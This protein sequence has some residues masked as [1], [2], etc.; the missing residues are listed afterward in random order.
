MHRDPQKFFFS[1][2]KQ[3]SGRNDDHEWLRMSNAFIL[4][5]LLWKV[6]KNHAGTEKEDLNQW[7]YF[8][9]CV[10]ILISLLCCI[11]EFPM[12]E[13]C[14]T[15]RWQY[16]PG[17]GV[18]PGPRA[19]EL[20]AKGKIFTRQGGFQ[21]GVYCLAL[22]PPNYLPKVRYLPV[23]EGFRWGCTVW[24]LCHRTICQR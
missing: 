3:V 4:C 14:I 9:N 24:P 15:G 18:L 11:S 8:D 21:V 10:K 22:V 17:G 6:Q 19:T 16:T 5:D 2:Y 7:T 13:S 12:D 20:S 23:R 1:S